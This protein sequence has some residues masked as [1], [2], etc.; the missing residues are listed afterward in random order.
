MRGVAN[1]LVQGPAIGNYMRKTLGLKQVCVI[2]DGT[3]YGLGF[4]RTVR[5]GLA[6]AE[7][8]ACSVTIPPGSG[9]IAKVLATSPDAV[10][11]SGYWPE[12]AELVRQLRAAGF[13]GNFLSG[14]GSKTSDFVHSAGA[15][16]QGAILSCPCGPSVVGL[17]DP[18]SNAFSRDYSRAFNEQPGTFSPEGYDLATIF[19]EGVKAGAVTRPAMLNFVRNYTGRGVGRT[20]NWAADGELAEPLIWIYKV[21]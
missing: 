14:D 13:F 7:D 11:Y 8:S 15:A 12:A 4:A 2:D 16:A 5:S 18:S 20:Y 6:A 9:D 19:I 21:Q 17:L 1:D 3:D 10:F